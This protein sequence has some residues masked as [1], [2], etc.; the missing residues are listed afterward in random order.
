MR[1]P[2]RVTVTGAA[3][4]IGYALL[5]RLAS[6]FCYGEDQPVILQLLE[7]TPAMKALEGTVMEIVDGAFPLVA[8][9]EISDD[10][11]KAFEGAN[12]GFLVGAM[13]RRAGM[14]RAD[15]IK[16]NGP[17]F[18]GQGN[19]INRVAA[20][21]IQ[22]VVVGNPCNTNALICRHAAPD[23][24]GDRFHAMTRLDQNRGQGQ[25][26]LKTGV[27]TDKVE[28]LAIWGNHSP[29]MFPDF[30]HATIDGKPATEVV[31]DDAWLKGDFFTTV[32][33]RGSAIIAARGASSAASAASAALDHMKTLWSGTAPGEWSSMGIMSD[34][35]YGVPEGL[36][37]S[38]PVTT[39]GRK[40]TIVPGI[41][42]GEWAQ[43]KIAASADELM[44]ERAAVAD[45]LG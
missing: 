26:A 2:I 33:K 24:P 27:S 37:Y 44:S 12:Q 31:G 38:F 43:G 35:S 7:I 15:L 4:N 20:P 32:T 30:L 28:N 14:V 9:I 25:L 45:L 40:A 23:V 6:G 36:I 8:G 18:V 10:P 19:A 42:H 3:G 22:V 29:T 17:I 5:F 13:P 11:S 39:T 16:A 34:G 21:D 41:E 1:T